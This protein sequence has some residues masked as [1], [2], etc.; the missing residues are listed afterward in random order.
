MY[1]KFNLPGF[2]PRI[3]KSN[4]EEYNSYKESYPSN[5][6]LSCIAEWKEFV[7]SDLY[8]YSQ[9]AGYTIGLHWSFNG[10][11]YGYEKT[12]YGNLA[13]KLD[14]HVGTLF[15]NLHFRKS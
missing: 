1:R 15:E 9:P 6:Y 14:L 12:T 7:L 11:K 3:F 13:T 8:S 2:T 4:E 5:R 10:W